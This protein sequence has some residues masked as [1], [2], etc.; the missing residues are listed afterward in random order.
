MG[1]G[2]NSV[3]YLPYICL[4]GTAKYAV[5]EGK[6]PPRCECARGVPRRPVQIFYPYRIY[7][8]FSQSPVYVCVCVYIV[9]YTTK[10][11]DHM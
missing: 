1:R 11:L 4:V 6:D 7:K 9:A 10:R 5:K 8:L 2:A 3:L